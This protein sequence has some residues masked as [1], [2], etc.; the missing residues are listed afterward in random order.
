MPDAPLECLIVGAGPAGLTA[1]IYLARFRRRFAILHDG[2]SRAALIARSHNLPGFPDGIGGTALLERMEAQARRYGARPE[3]ARVTGLARTEAAFMAATEAGEV[4]ARTVLLATG[5]RDR[6]PGFA[7]E[8]AALARGVLR[9][10]PICDGFE[11]IGQRIGV[12]GE[13][14]HGEQEA[15]FLRTYAAEVVLFPRAAVAEVALRER[16][17]WLRLADGS[18]E[19]VDTLYVAL[20]TEVHSGLLAGLGTRLEP[21]GSVPAEAHQETGTEGVYAAGDVVRGLDQI[22]VAM[23]EAAIAATAIHNRLRG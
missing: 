20:G 22:T 1:A 14:R 16:D 6:G 7:D 23:G 8:A 2:Q 10:C 17:V 15:A 11:A 13:G 9:Y 18:A 3:R 5:V 4:A 21:D 12:L 19:V